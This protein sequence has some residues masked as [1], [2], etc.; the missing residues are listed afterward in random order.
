MFRLGLKLALEQAGFGRVDAVADG[1]AAIRAL[2][3]GRYDVVILDVKMPGR[4]GLEVVST[5]R[6]SQ[7]ASGG[8]LPHVI[9]MSTFDQPAVVSK[10]EELGVQACIGKETP[11]E[12][13]ATL[14]DH[15]VQGSAATQRPVR[16]RVRAPSLTD[17]EQ[18]VLHLLCRGA[19]TKEI[20]AALTLSPETVKDYLSNL[21]AKFGVRDRAAAVHAAHALGWVALDDLMGDGP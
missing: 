14:I 15:L 18:D 8:D 13:L 5:L 11:P 7:T 17:R 4:N 1:D 12:S 10:A 19:S 21:Y 9:V 6:Q 20:A 3:E 2:S 16:S